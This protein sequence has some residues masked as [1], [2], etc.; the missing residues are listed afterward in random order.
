MNEPIFIVGVP[1]SGTTLLAAMLAAHS[2]ISCG[3]ETHF[4]R[5]LAQVDAATLAD[6]QSW[7]ELAAD[8]VCSISHA[9]FMGHEQTLLIHEYGLERGD[10]EAF[11]AGTTPSIAAMLSGLTEQHMRHSGKARW[12][13][14]TPDHLKNLSLIR[15]TFPDARIVRI[16]RDPRDVALSLTR[17]PWGAQTYVEGLLYWRRM[18]E[19]GEPFLVADPSS[20]SLRFEDLLAEPADTLRD[21]CTF[22]EEDFEEGMLDTSSTGKQVNSQSV[23]WKQKASEPIDTGRMYA[24]RKETTASQNQLAE[25]LVGDWLT[26]YDY[27]REARFTRLGEIHPDTIP[28]AEYASALESV[29]ASGIRF[30]SEYSGERPSARIYLGDPGNSA[31]LSTDKP[32]RLR[33]TL[34]ISTEIF[35]TSLTDG[36]VFWLREAEPGRWTGYLAEMLKRILA[37][38]SVTICGGQNHADIA[39]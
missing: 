10:I 24:W 16:I 11:L 9:G 29:A 36:Q 23:P 12:T 7:P 3:P 19:A 5:K 18:H 22:L 20:Y 8:F 33:D 30:W 26:A 39:A 25:A 34:A 28:I 32:A 17:V 4:F 2:R 21:L 37:S 14:K 6:P 38:R 13:E 1:R 15:Q 31:W 27:P 35:R